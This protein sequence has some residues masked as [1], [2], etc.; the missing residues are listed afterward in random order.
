MYHLV[1]FK[2]NSIKTTSISLFT[3]FSKLT[4]KLFE[5]NIV[6]K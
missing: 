2:T 1:V 4:N 5:A 6:Y 3:R